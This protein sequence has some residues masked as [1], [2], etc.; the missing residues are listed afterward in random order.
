[1]LITTN[2]MEFNYHPLI[3]ST[4]KM[5]G[6]FVFPPNEMRLAEVIFIT[7]T[8]HIVFS[9]YCYSMKVTHYMDY[10][11]LVYIPREKFPSIIHIP[12]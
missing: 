3:L 6:S 11:M 12:N 7:F 2:E 4:R 9:L 8:S 10:D 1:M 5:F